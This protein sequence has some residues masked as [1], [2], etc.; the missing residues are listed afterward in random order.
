MHL[1]NLCVTIENIF[2]VVLIEK[3]R[4]LEVELILGIIHGFAFREK[5]LPFTSNAEIVN[6][7]GN[8]INQELDE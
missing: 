1:W 7:Y 3:K 2:A 4:Y 6:L 8:I 5:F